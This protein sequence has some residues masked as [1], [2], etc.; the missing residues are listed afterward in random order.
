MARR[1]RHYKYRVAVLPDS[2][3][4]INSAGWATG[5]TASRCSSPANGI[6][7]YN[8]LVSRIAIYIKTVLFASF[9]KSELVHQPN[10]NSVT[11]Q[12]PTPI[13]VHRTWGISDWH[14]AY[15][16]RWLLGCASYVHILQQYCR[17][18]PAACWH[19]QLSSNTATKPMVCSI[20]ETET[21]VKS[22]FRTSI[23]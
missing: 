23:P 18:L 15:R 6:S 2:Y 7:N 8:K 17:H 16:K 3:L 9:I 5:C 19:G 11:F 13:L 20:V 12:C 14:L 10:H 1:P 21:K 22:K 4:A